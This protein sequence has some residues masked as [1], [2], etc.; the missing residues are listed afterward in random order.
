MKSLPYSWKR[1]NPDKVLEAR[2]AGFRFRSRPGATSSPRN[3]RMGVDYDPETGFS[4]DKSW[5]D[6]FRPSRIASGLDT[7]PA[8]DPNAVQSPGNTPP[9]PP[10][11]SEFDATGFLN[12]DEPLTPPTPSNRFQSVINSNLQYFNRKGVPVARPSATAPAQSGTRFTSRYG[13]GSVRTVDDIERERHRKSLAGIPI[14]G[15]IY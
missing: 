6:F 5:N 10:V 4:T 13:S 11:Q 1:D 14:V 8:P 12:Q 2:R 9:V 15:N 3:A 7:A